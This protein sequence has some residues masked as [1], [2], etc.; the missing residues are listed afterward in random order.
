MKLTTRHFLLPCM[1]ASYLAIIMVRYEGPLN[2]LT[3]AL[4]GSLCLAIIID[5]YE[6]PN[7][8]LTIA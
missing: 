5:R 8:A 3:I 4:H 2:A 7:N 6:G 1:E